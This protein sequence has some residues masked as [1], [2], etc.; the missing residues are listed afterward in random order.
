MKQFCITVAISA[1][2]FLCANNCIAQGD[3]I[4]FSLGINSRDSLPK[5]YFNIGLFSNLNHLDGVA[6][7]FLSN[8]ANIQEGVQFAL[9]SNVST[10]AKGLQFS[11]ISNIATESL[12]GVQITAVSNIAVSGNRA[13][14]LSGLSNV[15]QTSFRKGLQLS[16]LSNYS[17][18]LERSTQIG[19]MNSCGVGSKGTQIGIINIGGDSTVHKIGLV[20]INPQTRMQMMIYGGNTSKTNVALR[21]RNN[22]YYT[23]IGAGTH[24]LGL[25]DKFS[26]CLFYRKGFMMPLPIERF[27]LCTDLGYYHIENFDNEDIDTPERMYSLQA[28]A[29]IEYVLS[30]KVSFSLM[31][32]YGMTRYYSRNKFFERKPIIELGIVLF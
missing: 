13:F 31:G 12:T 10:K 5:T 3:N 7:N 9:I 4:N 23:I 28:R 25:D 21:F 29:G 15:C 17:A 2:C 20:N 8:F 30:S 11:S 32:G 27:M 24:Y 19:F 14:Q 26:G 16:L 6:I 1:F 22:S 18:Q